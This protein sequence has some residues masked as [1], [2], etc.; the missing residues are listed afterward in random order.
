MPCSSVADLNQAVA[1]AR[2]AFPAW[3][4]TPIKE[5]GSGIFSLQTFLERDLKQL[6]SLVAE[7]NGKN[8]GRSHCRNRK[9][10]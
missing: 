9:M 2:A 4:R 8:P 3:S 6:A 5:R 10:Y 1:A 7:E